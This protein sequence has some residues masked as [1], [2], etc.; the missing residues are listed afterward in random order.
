MA[1]T[2]RETVRFQIDRLCFINSRLKAS[3]E[4]GACCI[5][6]SV[7]DS[8]SPWIQ[9]KIDILNIYFPYDGDPVDVVGQRVPGFPDDAN[10]LSWQSNLFATFGFSG[11]GAERMTTLICDMFVHLYEIPADSELT[12]EIIDMRPEHK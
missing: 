11:L 7:A 6:F 1:N 2:I 4:G 10:V 12:T 9:A 3:I 5:G 8:E